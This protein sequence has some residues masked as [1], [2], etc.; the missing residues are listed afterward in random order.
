MTAARTPAGR[1]RFLARLGALGLGA[2]V[3]AA[4]ATGMPV[5][6]IWLNGDKGYHGVARIGERFT[7]DTGVVVRVE[8]PENAVSKFE[9][10]AAAGKGPDIWIW[11]HDRLGTYLASGLV[12]PVTPSVRTLAAIDPQAWSAWQ[13]QGRT[14]GFPL[15]ME[16]VSLLYNKALVARPP[17]TWDEVLQIDRRLAAQGRRAIA[18]WTTEA[19]YSWALFTAGGGYAFG[20]RP[21]GRYDPRDVGVAAEGARRGLRALMKLVEAGAVPR[22]SSYAEAESAMNEGR[23]GMTFNGPWA[24]RNLQAS[25]IDFGV[26][27]GPRLGGR[28]GGAFVGVLGAMVASGSTWPELAH[29]FIE[30]YLLSDEGL[31]AMDAHVPLGV[32]A[33]RALY[34]ERAADPRIAGSMA[35]I[36]AGELIP[37]LP[38]MSRFW[39]AMSAALQ[40]IVQGREGVDEG[41]ARAAARIRGDAS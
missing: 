15:A 21:D 19:Y 33:N 28:P 3:T 5:L 8:H 27:A 9:Q 16:G 29:E 40:N 13:Q 31:R 4:G 35:S 7:R 22:S 11:P 38:E 17:E 6:R 26:A 25:G 20:R 39:S 18:W 12:R 37:S 41:L 14:W 10:A 36:R 30:E 1:R 2:Q 32:P 24:W 34:E 23:V